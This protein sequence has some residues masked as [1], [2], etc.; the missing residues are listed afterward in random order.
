MSDNATQEAAQPVE[1][2]SSLQEVP[3]A[4]IRENPVA[5]RQVNRNTEQYMELV[6]SI[7]TE[8]LLNPIVVRPMKDPETDEEFYGLIDGLHRFTAAQDAGLKTIPAHVKSMEDAQVLVAQIIG[9]IHRIETRPVEYSKQLQK[10]L[11]QD[12]LLTASQ[13]A[14]QLGKSTTWVSERLGL[15]KIDDNISKLVDEGKI[16]LSNAFVLAKL[17]KEEQVAFV[18]RAM[19]MTP[20]EFSATV[21]ERKK[22]LD[23]ARREGRQVASGEFVAPIH[24]RKLKEV[25]AE[26]EKPEVGPALIRA[27]KVKDV[28]EAFALGIQWVLH[29]DPTSVEVAKQKDEDRK[30]E[31]QEKRD[32]AKNA[33]AKKKAEEAA[34]KAARLA[35]ESELIEGNA[36][37]A[38]IKEE[39]AKFDVANGLKDGKPVKKD[40]SKDG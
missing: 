16:N 23:K 17:P 7:R 35:L 1:G 5:L 39:L 34:V 3:L 10:I 28:A 11:A 12:P 37:E 6:D 19:T 36:D 15:L 38:K 13:L 18:D 9:N 40:E 27:G 20:Q 33:K 14:K 4:S 22:A 31:Q 29:Q 24:M 21:L 26:F 25:R 2:I 32:L 30:R 8:G